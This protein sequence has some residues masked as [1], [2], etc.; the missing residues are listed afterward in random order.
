MAP[1]NLLWFSFFKFTIA[2]SAQQQQQQ[3]TVIITGQPSA[4]VRHVQPVGESPVR[5][6]CPACSADVLTSVY[7][8][9]GSMVWVV[10]IVLAVFG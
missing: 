9:V 4:A 6:T 1:T 3:S 2:Y 7:Y 10:C 5:T 8:E